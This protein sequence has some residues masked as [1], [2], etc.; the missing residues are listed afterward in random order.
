MICNCCIIQEI[1]GDSLNVDNYTEY[2]KKAILSPKNVDVDIINERVLNILDGN[3]ITYLSTDSIDNCS[4]ND[5]ETYPV[6]FLNSCCP[7][8]MPPHKLSLKVGS[9]IILLRNLNTKRGLCNG[10]R[11]AVKVLKSNLIIAEVLIGTAIGETVFIPRIDLAPST[12]ELPFIL[13]RRQFPVKLAFS[14]TINKAQGQTLK[15]VGIYLPDVV[16]G[17]GQLYVAI[18]RVRRSGDVKI[19]ISEGTEQGK[20]VTNCN[21][22]YTKNVVYKEVLTNT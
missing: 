5:E 20:L 7:N 12:T 1:F 15:K 21:K 17:H 19:K 2:S 14:M 18:S 10:T 6:E 16:F 11:L 3:V 22:L 4:E 9:I 8:G 13:R